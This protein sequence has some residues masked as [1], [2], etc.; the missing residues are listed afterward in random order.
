MS[1]SKAHKRAKW[2]AAGW[3]GAVEVPLPSGRRLDALSRDG[4]RGTEVETSGDFAL[5]L[6]AISRL[7]ESGVPKKVLRVPQRHMR[8]A[9]AALRH[10]GVSAWVQNMYGS[11]SW[12]I[13]GGVSA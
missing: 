8:M 11:E 10:A 5:L 1:E 9:A 13:P 6:L 3:G 2:R 7:V 4:R 12:W